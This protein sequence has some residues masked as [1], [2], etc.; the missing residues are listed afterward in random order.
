MLVTPGKTLAVDV[1]GSK[2]HCRDYF[3]LL[4][5]HRPVLFRDQLPRF[6]QTSNKRLQP[7]RGTFVEGV[8]R[9]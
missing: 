7:D 3:S 5:V 9:Y 2:R 8:V 1:V 4:E 6:V